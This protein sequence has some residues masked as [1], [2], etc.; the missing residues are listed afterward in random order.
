[1]RD[2]LYNLSPFP[3]G[4]KA[5]APKNHLGDFRIQ[6]QGDLSFAEVH[7]EVYRRFII[8]TQADT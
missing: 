8:R 6:I 1:M 2:E 5:V 7:I 3:S 4:F